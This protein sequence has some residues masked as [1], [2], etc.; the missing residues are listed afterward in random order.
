MLVLISDLLAPLE[1]V[2]LAL[3]CLTARGQEVLVFQILDPAEM[4]FD[5]ERPELFEDL[6]TGRR[7]YVDPE[8]I[9]RDYRQRIGQHL[10]DVESVC[11]RLGVTY[12]RLTT[13]M[14]LGDGSAICCSR[15]SALATAADRRPGGDDEEQNCRLS[16]ADC[17]SQFT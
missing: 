8:R 14:P 16:I 7:M 10:R 17:K 11:A 5:F 3:G 1:R 6:E 2:E 13:D 9:R 4:A 15:V 12:R